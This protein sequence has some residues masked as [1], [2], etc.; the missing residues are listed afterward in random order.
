MKHKVI[1]GMILTILIGVMAFAGWKIWEEL[2]EYKIGEEAYD[3]IGQYVVIPTPLAPEEN[4][5]TEEIHPVGPESDGTVWPEVDFAALQEIN[6]D[7]VAWIYIE[8]TEINYPV[9]QGDDNSYYLKHLFTGEW[10]SSGCIFLDSRNTGDFS[11]QHNVIYGHHMKNGSM[12]S[13]LDS[14]KKQDFY[15]SHPV[16]LILTPDQNYKMEI[17]SAYVA[18]V[19]EN[20]WE[21]GFTAAGYKAWLGEIAAKTCITT[22]IV[23]AVT[24]RVLTLST[25]SYEFNNAR[26]V[27]HGILR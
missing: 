7:I 5:T 13:G 23:P 19:E 9:V 18:N 10:N 6:H 24:D 8:G 25:C 12:F 27:V 15:E 22:N 16:V 3:E 17:F 21:M 14:Y 26:F 4:V 11:D 2:S 1:Y 20:A